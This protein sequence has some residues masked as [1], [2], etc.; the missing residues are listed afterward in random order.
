[1][2]ELF[3][4]GGGGFATEVLFVLERLNQI[5]KKWSS[6]SIIDDNIA[7]GAKIR[8]YNVVGDLKYLLDLE[9]KIDVVITINEPQIRCKIA[10]KIKATKNNVTF[11]NIYDFTSII[12]YKYLSIGEGNIVMHHVILSTNLVIGN[13]NIFNSYTG[14]GHD[15]EMGDFNSFNPR[16]AISGNVI[17]NN[18]N[19][20]GV[21]STV[22]QNKKIGSRNQVWM[23]TTIVKNLK[24]DSTYFGIPAK[25][26]D[27]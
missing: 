13:F 17:M 19:S 9:Q 2:K 16:V 20:F 7:P 24:D 10:D 6:I 1:M 18:L 4:I 12:D 5:D 25:K 11:P 3:L 27:L 15:S 8:N 22:L 26:I 21:N 23:N 14:I